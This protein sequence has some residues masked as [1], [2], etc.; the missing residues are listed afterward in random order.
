MTSSRLPT[1]DLEAF[2]R[3]QGLR[4]LTLVTFSADTLR[5]NQLTKLRRSLPACAIHLRRI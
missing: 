1:A 3:F 5:A 2:A 4:R